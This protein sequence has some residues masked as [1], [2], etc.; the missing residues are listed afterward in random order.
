MSIN[1]YYCSASGPIAAGATVPLLDISTLIQEVIPDGAFI[2]AAYI[3]KGTFTTTVAGITSPSVS[4][5]SVGWANNTNA[6]VPT[7]ALVTTTTLT[8]NSTSYIQSGLTNAVS[9]SQSLTLTSSGAITDGT[10]M[11]VVQTILV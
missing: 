8:A 1:F 11:I 4:T 7:S 2:V 3:G 6:I 10:F 5:I 9:G